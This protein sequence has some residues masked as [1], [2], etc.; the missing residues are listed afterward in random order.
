MKPQTPPPEQQQSSL[1]EPELQHNIPVKQHIVQ[2]IKAPVNVIKQFVE[3]DNK[4][5]QGVDEA[6]LKDVNKKIKEEDKKPKKPLFSFHRKPKTPKPTK[7]GA[8][9]EVARA[10]KN[11][12]PVGKTPTKP[13]STK[14]IFVI[15]AAAVAAIGLSVAAIYAFAPKKSLP[16]NEPASNASTATI[17]QSQNAQGTKVTAD[18]LTQDV[19]DLNSKI[20]ALNDTQDFNTDN[21]SDSALG[22]Q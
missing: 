6:T 11:A 5:D 7:Q 13:K 17:N 12:K 10:P 14:P 16:S 8:K 19:S 4:N 21:I 1:I 9:P 15:A 22:L 2:D 20:N 18:D 3:H